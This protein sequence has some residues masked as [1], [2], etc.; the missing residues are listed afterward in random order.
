MDFLTLTN[1]HS[2]RQSTRILACTR[3]NL[4]LQDGV[5]VRIVVPQ[6][7]EMGQQ[8]KLVG[9]HNLLGSWEIEQAP[10]MKWVNGSEWVYE[11]VSPVGTLIEFKC[12]LAND[13]GEMKWEEGENHILQVPHEAHNPPE[14]MVRK[15]QLKCNWGLGSVDEHDRVQVSDEESH[16]P[17]Y[18]TMR[19]RVTE[20]LMLALEGDLGGATFYNSNPNLN[21]EGSDVIERKGSLGTLGAYYSR[22]ASMDELD[23]ASL[24]ATEWL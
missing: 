23:Q 20:E 4:P 10:S 2:S 16:E 7:C 6:K 9:G 13:N 14:G 21:A 17:E 24:D 19:T 12:V 5:S 11:I 8:I 3:D 22:L 15:L 1:A 18:V